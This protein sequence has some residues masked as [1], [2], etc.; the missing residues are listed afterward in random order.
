MKLKL[1]LILFLV[2]IPFANAQTICSGGFA[3]AYPCNN[4]DLMS[5]LT[6]SQLGGTSGIEGNDI[7]G[8]TD[9]FD[10]KEYAIMGLTSHTAFI[11]I[12]IPTSPV[13][14]GKLPTASVNSIWRDIKVYNNHAFIVSEASGH[15]MQV[16][17]LTRL[18]GVVTPQT[19]TADAHYTGF[20]RC[21][22]IAI[23]E[24]NGFAYAV[25][26][27]TY[28]S[29]GNGVSNGGGPHII[30]IQ[31]PAAPV[32]VNEY[33]A[34]GYSHD[35]QIVVYNGPDTEHVGKQLY[36]GSN[37]N[38]VVVVDV[39]N[40]LAPVLISSFTYT[41]TAYTHQ[42]WLTE[43][44]N[45][46]ILGDEIDEQSFGFNTKTIIVDMTDLDV[47]VLKWNY[48]GQ[49]AAIDH[50]GYTLGN[51]FYLA[52]YRAGLR[53]MDIS[54]IDTANMTEVG[55]FD[56]Y[57]SSNSNQFNGAWSVYPYFASGSIIISD[58]ES[59]L[60]IVKK[61][62]VLSNNNYTTSNISLYPNPTDGLVSVNLDIP[63]EKI[64]IFNLM[65]AKVMS[66]NSLNSNEIQINVSELASGMYLVQINDS[67][68]QKL[69]V[70]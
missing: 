35:A 44:H 28:V 61:N 10:G 57:P 68:S 60:F 21:H 54:G 31:T 43:D 24:V 11:D 15:G 30:N 8:W 14:L 53:I 25:G 64:E 9:S 65:G 50:N 13:Y 51:D 46:F 23:D 18:R 33:N 22:N 59:G 19:F 67:I 47:P 52:N 66:I 45:Y 58:I 2:L 34:Q 16:F 1:T 29:G 55:F 20:G 26:T 41:N 37:E 7:W 5:Q 32:F 40:K 49:T 69:I 70:K 62:A 3:G 17:D 12:T 6:I 42:G 63:I 4:I 56:T 27:R 39:T 48:N 38:R 36:F